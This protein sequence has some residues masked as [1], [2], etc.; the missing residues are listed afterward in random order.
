MG[1]ILLVATSRIHSSTK[2]QQTAACG[3]YHNMIDLP[4][5]GCHGGQTQS[6]ARASGRLVMIPIERANTGVLFFG[7][8][9]VAKIVADSLFR[10]CHSRIS[11][12]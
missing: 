8:F 5:S 3:S 4:A 7:Y 6:P 9:A 1:A 10:V 12:N 11:L 2:D